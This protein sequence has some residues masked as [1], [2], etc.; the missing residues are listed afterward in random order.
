[1]SYDGV[2]V[3]SGS[4]G[5]VTARR[6]V[7]SGARVH[8]LGTHTIF[9]AEVHRAERFEGVPLLYYRGQLDWESMPTRTG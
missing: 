9:I 5:W 3:G 8:V 2:I 7:D 1:M 4:A 6:L